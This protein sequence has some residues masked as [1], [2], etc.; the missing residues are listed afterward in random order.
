MDKHSARGAQQLIQALRTALT[1]TP[2][3]IPLHKHLADLLFLEG[4]YADAIEACKRALDLNSDDIEVKQLLAEAYHANNQ[5]DIAV[6]IVEELLRA[7]QPEPGIYLLAAR[8]Y[9]ATGNV[10]L[11]AEMYRDAITQNPAL[12]DDDLHS[13]L[14]ITEIASNP[15][16]PDSRVFVT[17]DETAP[18]IA[19]YIEQPDIS[20]RDVGGMEKLKEEIRLKIIYPITHPDIYQA[21]GKSAGGG[22]LMYGPPGCGKTYLARATAGEVSARAAL[23]HLQL[24]NK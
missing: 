24:Q 17:I 16:A 22:I 12:V 4:A 3:A 6:I 10:R 18:E 7:P 13:H 11:A 23:L 21:Y 15:G 1:V 8:V 5:A 20:F 9:F 19:D 2:D 14:T